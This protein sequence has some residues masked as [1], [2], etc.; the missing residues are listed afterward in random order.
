MPTSSKPLY[1]ELATQDKFS[2]PAAPPQL[3]CLLSNGTLCSYCGQ[4]AC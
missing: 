3:T 4:G 1:E 2:K